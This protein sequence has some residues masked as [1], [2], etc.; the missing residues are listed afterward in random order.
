M[1]GPK[2]SAAS[3]VEP[4]AIDVEIDDP[5]SVDRLLEITGEN[6]SIDA[7]V[8]SLKEATKDPEPKAGIA[9]LP[10][11]AKPALPTDLFSE[12][13]K[14]VA[15]KPMSVP[16]PLPNAVTVLAAPAVPPPLPGASASSASS[17][18]PPP[19]PAT[20]AQAISIAPAKPSTAPGAPARPSAAPPP[21]P[22]ATA[23]Q[24]PAKPSAAPPPLPPAAASAGAVSKA[25]E[26]R[27][28][29][30]EATTLPIE[31]RAA[32]KPAAPPTT[33]DA[34]KKDADA[35][36]SQKTSA[37]SATRD[38]ERSTASAAS[39]PARAE[40]GAS[41]SVPP[42][43]PAQPQPQAQREASRDD[44]PRLSS[45]G[46]VVVPP[47]LPRDKNKT[48]PP[49]SR[50]REPAPE[51]PRPRLS[52]PA[53]P[54]P[55]PAVPVPIGSSQASGTAPMSSL[56]ASPPHAPPPVP[57]AARPEP[58]R[59]ESKREEARTRGLPE[60]AQT[61]VQ[62]LET[63]T[64]LLAGA[65]DLDTVGLARA[66]LE[67][68]IADE[69]IGD[70]S[71]VNAHAEAALRV[72]PR[73]TT[74]HGILRRRT[75][76]KGALRSM[77]EHLEVEIAGASTE[78]ASVELLTERA[79][80]LAARGDVAAEALAAWEHV[81]TRSPVHTAALKGLEAGLWEETFTNESVEAYEALDSHLGDLADAY[82][83]QQDLSAWLHVE[84]G[85]LL[86]RR[87]GRPR[88]ARNAFERAL[89]I[90]PA[91]GAV[92]SALV[93]H[94]T[95]TGDFGTLA[96]LLE[97]EA[98]LETDPARA[99]RLDLDAACLCREKLAD[100]ARA[101]FLLER[102]VSRI[103]T[104]DT[105]DRRVL[106]ELSELYEEAGQLGDAV[107][108]RA[109]RARY[110]LEPALI[111]HDRKQTADLR[112]KLGD[113]AGAVEDIRAAI[114][115]DTDDPRLFETQ[116]RLLGVLGRHDERVALWL[117][118][119]AESED[120]QKR[121]R[122]LTRAAFVLERDL[123]RP[124]EATQH[125]KAAWVATPGDAEVLD[126]LSRLMSPA[127][128]EP[129]TGEVR[130][131]VELYAQAA[132]GS[133]D[134]GRRVAYL[135]KVALLWEELLGDPGRATRVYEEI[136]DTEPGRRGA[137]LG[138][139]RS[140]AR[141]GDDRALARALLAEAKR[142][143]LGSE[144]LSLKV[145]A[146]DALSRVDPTRAIAVVDDV[147]SEDEAHAAARALE[148]RLHEDAGRWERVAA[149]LRARIAN[150]QSVEEKVT[151]WLS[152]ARVCDVR[153]GAKDEA[154]DALEAAKKIDPV[155]PVPPL[156]IA[157]VLRK[158]G[159]YDGLR[160]ALERLGDDTIGKEERARFFVRAAELDEL[161]LG[162][163]ASA[164][165]LYARALAET[166]DDPHVAERLERVLTRRALAGA[167]TRAH[168]D[169]SV[170]VEGLLPIVDLLEARLQIAQSREEQLTLSFDLA[171]LLVEC[172]KD[173]ARA[174]RLLDSVLEALP[175]HV[176]S[177]R[178]LELLARRTG[179]YGDLARVLAREGA[180][181]TDVR[182]RTGALWNLAWL[183]EWRLPAQAQEGSTTYAAL[184]ELDPTDPGALEAT[185]RRELPNARRGEPRAR[186]AVHTSLRALCALA[187]EDGPLIAL[188][189]R[190]GLLVEA[191]ALETGETDLFR[192]ALERFRAALEIDT[193]SVT[194]ATSLSRLATRLGDAPGQ[195]TSSL[196]LAELAARPDVRARYLV[197]AA[198]ILLV[199]DPD[200]SDR[201]RDRL[202]PIEGRSERAAT[203]LEAAIA[204]DP[205][206]RAA[207]ARLAHVRREQKRSERIVEIFFGALSRAKD[208]D[209]VVLLGTEIAKVARDDL[210]E[211]TLAI[212]AMRKV[213]EAAP[214][215]V[216]SLL[217]L[218]ELCIAQRAWPEAVE[219]LEEVAT[220]GREPGPRLTALFALASVFERVLSRPE[221]AEN[222]LRRALQVDPKSGR[223]LRALVHRLVAKQSEKGPT[224][225]AP[226][227]LPIRLEIATLL[228]Q[229]AE[230]EP[231][232]ATKTEIYL[233]LAEVRASVKDG[234]ATERAILDALAH[235]PG[236]PRAEERF[237]RLYRGPDG[238]VDAVAYA[239]GLG[240]LVARG[241]ELDRA[242]ATWFFRL[243]RVEVRELARLKDGT[244]HLRQAIKLKPDLHDARVELAS[245]LARL[246]AHDEAVTAVMAMI[247]PSPK[248]LVSATDASVAL[249][250][251]E[252]SLGEGRRPEEA[253][254]VSELRAI[255]G[256]LD[257]GRNSWL[258]ARRLGPMQ[259]H[260]MPLDRTT[261]FTH[262]VPEE[263][264][265][266]LTEVAA[267]VSG[268]EGRILRT[269]LSELG[270]TSKDRI[271]KRS[272]HP[273]RTLMDRL[274]K[275][276]G[277]GDLEL[278]VA[279]QAH[280]VRVVAQDVPWIAVPP[281]LLE[282]P[283]QTQLSSL[284]RALARVA[285]FVPWLEE[286][287]G[288]H[289]EAYLVACVRQVVPA[290][291]RDEMD[292]LQQKLV[293]QYEPLVQKEISRKQ[294]Q[295]LEKVVPSLSLPQGKPV[296]IDGIVAAL[297]R[298]ELRT[299]YVLTGDLLA[300]IDE[301][302][303][304]DTSFHTQTDKA[305][306]RAVE[307]VLDHPYAG[308]V[309]RF[310]LG[311]EATALRRRVGSTWAG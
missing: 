143:E 22:V 42:P 58:K 115:L 11:Q 154:L 19:V 215:S 95:A 8:E 155:H 300:T 158:A 241:R 244:A 152:L 71:R 60:Y 299:A 92:R 145:R 271:G 228:E 282:L 165:K 172:G 164:A 156:E 193:S 216:P 44:E 107:R 269:D 305:G 13:R 104:A 256:D 29:A 146:A 86:E 293:L 139:L 168:G 263:G 290:Y 218:A 243:G 267:A 275:A 109:I 141:V 284:G 237:E 9:P 268:L 41:R 261:L 242:D 101:I 235:T 239:R 150:A 298:A 63:R 169:V 283:E 135:E 68:A 287:P 304:L 129:T 294:R 36:S 279:P 70:D 24:S 296:P 175:S 142:T 80:L 122:A 196:A 18:A 191:H 89:G 211:L 198:E 50:M 16:P 301:L 291:G 183:E 162:N 295:A 157:R 118:R 123:G 272:G 201:T 159:D 96:V 46:S 119:A 176:P 253:I 262:V 128:V 39:A 224:G 21:L 194:A 234:R 54:P 52:R 249:E 56:A 203:H 310:A 233:Q 6:W 106:E 289:A 220:K 117:A 97:E 307:A 171:G 273:L 182:A 37:S 277:L 200:E 285:L 280:R 230:V 82:A 17:V 59:E 206:A 187:A 2:T 238:K 91:I 217:M 20:S 72:D 10:P 66:H 303:G 212:D 190:L 195:L 116:D 25:A 131:L 114:E 3:P 147:L 67:L 174:K 309:V 266:A 125:L 254:V 221:D 252:R 148:T 15:P 197:D 306:R 1:E 292:V 257:E 140:A 65:E 90:D 153:L 79:R 160:A 276:L 180:V 5:L 189:L 23:S 250:V 105:T 311:S 138:L 77:L 127:Q 210:K 28:S 179:S 209:A 87:L 151:L 302:R 38:D 61:L 204:A 40:L 103:P 185:V 120:A 149:S 111:V 288:P 85:L 265:H 161:R 173:P 134:P 110:V 73:S 26:S 55:A 255:M 99:S 227:K 35:S 222:A 31:G 297:A 170:Y 33:A 214:G 236:H 84:R 12:A 205:N 178:L 124:V 207:I 248:P 219:A 184:L 51:E 32:P 34:P 177:L 208:P 53:P 14:S 48:I 94:V 278:V 260:H 226:Q 231:D 27:T 62:L 88:A 188:L 69:S 240:A 270:V 199:R 47:P 76:G 281:S 7:Q 45:R 130:K 100:D 57:V 225:E 246:G 121:T 308:D 223:A 286:L 132:A 74:A 167:P 186:R 259:S 181:F 30:D 251:L 81:L 136:L 93:R 274:A 245:G 247:T 137:I 192:S 213:R 75:F 64:K 112:E 264:R 258:R 102:A 4:E 108:V 83:S 98:S 78:A 202:G 49:E 126:A 133:R 144:A 43:L 229:L 163:D 166:P 113:F 232:F